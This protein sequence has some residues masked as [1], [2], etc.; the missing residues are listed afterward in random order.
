MHFLERN[1]YASAL[2][3]L[4]KVSINNLFAR[5]VLE[6]HVRGRVFVDDI[7]RPR[8]F[9]VV[10]PYG[11]SLLYGDMEDG[12]LNS[13][14]RDYLLGKNGLR[15]TGEFLQVFPSDL[16]EKIDALLGRNLGTVEENGEPPDPSRPVIKHK[17]INFRFVP[18]K[19]ARARK[20][21]NLKAH[22]FQRIDENMFSNIR[23]SVVPKKF[24]DGASD[25]RQKGIGFSLLKNG[26]I[27]ASSFSSFVHDNMLELGMETEPEFRRKGF[28]SII[29][30]KLIDYCLERNLEPIWACRGGNKASYNLAVKL[31]FEPVAYLPYYE[32]AG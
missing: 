20:D 19:Y 32:L 29:T 2:P 26:R 5:S 30:A 28:A 10:H 7:A 24:W 15:K 11:M 6:N 9:Y 13:G 16:E 21:L 17:R 31:G 22:D 27:A 8:A 18:K 14:L 25:F 23:G 3:A 12:F 1:K 4:K